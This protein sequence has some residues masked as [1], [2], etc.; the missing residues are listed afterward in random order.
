MKPVH[1]DTEIQLDTPDT[2]AISKASDASTLEKNISPPNTH[3]SAWL[4]TACVML[5]N[6][7]CSIT[8]TTGSSAPISMSE[9]MQVDFSSLN[10]LSNIGAI[11]NAVLSLIAPWVYHR[12]GVKRSVGCYA[13]FII[14][15]CPNLCV[16]YECLS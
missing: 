15:Q 8:W 1:D 16:Y 14:S 6:M 12:L 10:W 13:D 5:V 11:S 9:W 7:A 2:N 4:V 3:W